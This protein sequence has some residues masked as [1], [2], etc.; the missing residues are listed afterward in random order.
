[1]GGFLILGLPLLLAITFPC[2]SGHPCPIADFATGL[3]YS[4]A[5][6]ALA[7]DIY[8]AFVLRWAALWLLLVVPAQLYVA[9]IVGASVSCATGQGCL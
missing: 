7:L 6:I 8:A 3:Y 1:M 9:F 4:S 5:L 2:K